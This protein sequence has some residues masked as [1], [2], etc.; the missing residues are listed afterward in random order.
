MLFIGRPRRPARPAGGFEV[1][2]ATVVVRGGAIVAVHRSD[3]AL[4]ADCVVRD[5][6]DLA[7]L[8]G[9]VDAGARFG[10]CGGLRAG[11]DSDCY[12][13][14]AAGTRGGGRRHRD[15]AGPAVARRGRGRGQ[16]RRGARGHRR[17]EGVHVDA[18]LACRLPASGRFLRPAAK[19]VALEACLTPPT[20]AAPAATAKG[21]EACVAANGTGGRPLLL[22][23]NLIPPEDL[24]AASP[25]RLLPASDRREAKSPLL[26]LPFC[27]VDP[28][29]S[30][31]YSARGRPRPKGSDATPGLSSLKLPPRLNV[32]LGTPAATLTTRMLPSMGIAAALD[33]PRIP[34]LLP[35][36]VEPDSARALV[37]RSSFFK[38]SPSGLAGR[39]EEIKSSTRLQSRTSRCRRRSPRSASTTPCPRRAAA[40]AAADEAPLLFKS[41][42]DAAARWSLAAA[43]EPPP[44]PEEEDAEVAWTVGT[45]PT[46]SA[47]L[48]GPAAA[49]V[50]ASPTRQESHFPDRGD[51]NAPWV[52]SLLQ[53][54]LESYQLSPGAAPPQ[55]PPEARSLGEAASARSDLQSPSL[56]DK[57]LGYMPTPSAFVCVGQ[58][59]DGDGLRPGD[60][61]RSRSEPFPLD[62]APS[63]P[64]ETSAPVAIPGDASA[65]QKARRKKPPPLDTSRSPTSP[66]RLPRAASS[67]CLG[68]LRSPSPPRLDAFRSPNRGA[69]ASSARAT[70]DFPPQ[71]PG[72]SPRLSRVASENRAPRGS[73]IIPTSSLGNL[74]E[75]RDSFQSESAVIDKPA[76]RRPSASPATS[77]T[78]GAA[79]QSPPP[80]ARPGRRRPASI[81]IFKENDRHTRRAIRKE[82]S[83][84]CDGQPSSAGAD[85]LGMQTAT[86]LAEAR[87]LAS[88]TTL[89]ALG[90]SA[91]AV[92]LVVAE[93]KVPQKATVYKVDPPIRHEAHRLALWGALRDGTLSVVTSGHAPR[94]PSSKMLATGDFVRAAAG[95]LAGANQLLLPALWAAAKHE[96]FGLGDVARWLAA[97]P[98]RLLGLD[99]KGAIAVGNDADF[100]VFADG[101]PGGYDVLHGERG[102]PEQL[103]NTRRKPVTCVYQGADLLGDVRATVVR[104]RLAFLDGRFRDTGVG[105]VLEQQGGRSRGAARASAS[106]ATP[107][108]APLAG[109]AQPVAVGAA[110]PARAGPQPRRRRRAARPRAAAPRRLAE[111][112]LECVLALDDDGG[113]DY[114]SPDEL[115]AWFARVVVWVER[116]CGLTGE[117]KFILRP[118][119]PTK[120]FKVTTGTFV[121]VYDPRGC[122]L[123]ERFA[124]EKGRTL[125]IPVRVGDVAERDRLRTLSLD[126]AGSLETYVAPNDGGRTVVPRSLAFHREVSLH[127]VGGL[128]ASD[129]S[130]S[131]TMHRNG[132]RYKFDC[133]L[134]QLRSSGSVAMAARLAE[135][136]GGTRAVLLTQ[137][138]SGLGKDYDGRECQ[139]VMVRIP[140]SLEWIR[141]IAPYMWPKQEFTL[142]LRAVDEAGLFRGKGGSQKEE[143]DAWVGARV[144]LAEACAKVKTEAGQQT[145]AELRAWRPYLDARGR[146]VRDDLAKT[147]GGFLDGDAS[148][149]ADLS[150]SIAQSYE[151]FLDVISEDLNATFGTT[152]SVI[153]VPH[154]KVSVKQPFKALSYNRAGN[155]ALARAVLR[156]GFPTCNE[157]FPA[158]RAIANSS[159]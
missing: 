35:P 11:S 124:A 145:H 21:L 75:L 71:R 49:R 72:F 52:R 1:A 122:V 42:G 73:P 81:K 28:N 105:A 126:V 152:F 101:A 130:T 127:H 59:H 65:P 58:K 154:T 102:P 148:A 159:P 118:D 79:P 74:V 114:P 53:A 25:Y 18:A 67:D 141:L 15:D 10:E 133:D 9:L 86:L 63:R 143:T 83:L 88:N 100:V 41:I 70:F 138:A 14:F 50:Y 90:G 2:A 82:Y 150:F 77:P 48:S 121:A 129:Q 68:G 108:I 153:R 111:V 140:A 123:V 144:K 128:L 62:D 20:G 43:P 40:A 125:S 3:E 8:P 38:A 78:A 137:C 132:R 6:G 4:P 106:A 110:P 155:R 45:P 107:L 142:I 69:S 57:L 84:Y 32:T 131:F 97:E 64:L 76:A 134:R 56:L 27:Q 22:R 113:D 98:A 66:A 44:P 94:P 34:D 116:R 96:G 7:V 13:G 99:R 139:L 120:D 85:G 54:E 89:G 12:E 136:I 157:K 135:M 5:C 103:P 33:P 117:T 119:S 36:P 151:A 19:C 146:I 158:L 92:H 61:A 17:R 87:A 115:P 30:D 16:R 104:G 109:R 149:Q 55:P 29:E 51:P 91:T 112:R 95:T 23:S 147:F 39:R 37:D 60:R 156:T 47:F 31:A 24:E 80:P 93:E 46:R 26:L